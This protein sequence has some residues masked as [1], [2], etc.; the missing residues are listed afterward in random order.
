MAE[1]LGEKMMARLGVW[2]GN[3][4]FP[5]GANC[6][7]CH[8][9]RLAALEDCLCDRCREELKNLRVPPE[10]CD[11]C[12]SPVKKG[13]KCS[14]CASALMKEIDRVFA[15]YQYKNAVRTL[16]HAFKFNACNEALPI[17]A[18]AMEMALAERDFD[19]LVPVPLHPKRLRQRGVN[20]ALLMAEALARRTG[21]P[22]CELLRRVHYHRPQSLLSEKERM[23]NV[24]D[25]FLAE[26]TAKGLKIL[27][28]DDV[29]TTGSTAHACA[30]ALKKAGAY[31]VSLCTAAVV[32]KYPRKKSRP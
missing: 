8:D 24:E 6:L 20:Q 16:I 29:R 27:L 3:L 19:C 10:A 2:V 1:K 9:P 4:L 7:C 15:P 13:K 26:E 5:R 18:D 22:V 28:I 23:K 32:Y 17:L 12:L 30:K 14:R 11:R 21:I 25:A 31:S